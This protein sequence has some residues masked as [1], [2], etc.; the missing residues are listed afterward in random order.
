MQGLEWQT[1]AQKQEQ[2]A[3]AEHLALRRAARLQIRECLQHNARRLPSFCF[4][5]VNALAFEV[6]PKMDYLRHNEKR[7]AVKGNAPSG[8]R[9]LLDPPKLRDG[10]E[11]VEVVEME[12]RT[13]RHFRAVQTRDL[14]TKG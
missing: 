2:A 13:F 8:T 9:A 4:R 3:Q 5:F 7:K 11:L 14:V 12:G 1:A 6:A 10:A